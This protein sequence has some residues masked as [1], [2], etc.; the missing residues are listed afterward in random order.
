MGETRAAL[1]STQA[2]FALLLERYRG[3]LVGLALDRT[4]RL[5]VAEEIAQDA[6][7]KAWEHR[8]SLRD[9]SAMGPW[10][11]RIGINCCIAW[12]RRESRTAASLT[13][14]PEAVRWGPPAIEE[15]IRR[16]T[17]REV[18]RA[19]ANLPS[20]TRVAVIMHAMGYCRG[21]IARF[22]CVPE[23]TVRGRLARA[24]E[25]LRQSLET[26]LHATLG[27]K[28]EEKDG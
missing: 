14:L 12:Q 23:S 1:N 5:D 25:R 19:L 8:S 16:D 24:R 15:L 9:Q 2:D 18:R 20:Q 26:R 17:I 28:K 22:L 13:A 7:V 4:G 27:K 3:A 10:L 21:E 11:F 6:I